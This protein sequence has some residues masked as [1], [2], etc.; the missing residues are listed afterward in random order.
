[1]D[2][3]FLKIS[4]KNDTKKWVSA[5]NAR[6]YVAFKSL[7]HLKASGSSDVIITGDLHADEFQIQLSGASDLK[8]SI[9]ARRLNLEESGASHADLSGNV[10]EF[11]VQSSG[12]SELNAYDL[13]SDTCTVK[14]SGA[15]DVQVTVHKMFN[16]TAHGASKVRYKGKAVVQ[17]VKSGGASVIRVMSYEL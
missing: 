9:E 10:K 15:S 1:M 4:Y 17:E 8:A 16:A 12:A 2:N 7:K 13:D 14:A 5:K 6:A 3:G 11:L